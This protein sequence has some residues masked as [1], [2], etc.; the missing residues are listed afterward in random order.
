MSDEI[1]RKCPRCKGSLGVSPAISVRDNK[2]EICVLCANEEGIFDRY[3]ETL[4][5]GQK[6]KDLKLKESRWLN[7]R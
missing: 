1:T 2:T 3:I 4:P 7:E 6:S 5:D